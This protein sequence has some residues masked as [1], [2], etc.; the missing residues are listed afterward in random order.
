MSNPT[1]YPWSIHGFLTATFKDPESS[2]GYSSVRGTGTLVSEN[3]I[4]TAAHCLHRLNEQTSTFESP[5]NIRFITGLQN[6][7]LIFGKKMNVEIQALDFF[8]HPKYLEG[9]TLDYDFGLVKLDTPIG[10]TTGWASLK[11]YEEKQLSKLKINVT[12]YPWY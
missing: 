1:V 7:W 9:N 3:C 6:A 4:L 12:G 11:Y 5:V 10:K 2:S 8:V